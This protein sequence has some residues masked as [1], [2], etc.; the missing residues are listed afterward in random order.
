MCELGISTSE[1]YHDLQING[2]HICLHKYM[3]IYIEENAKR[4]RR[5]RRKL[6]FRTLYRTLK[7]H[8]N[9]WTRYQYYLTAAAVVAVVG[10]MTATESGESIVVSTAEIHIVLI[11]HGHESLFYSFYITLV[12]ILLH[13]SDLAHTTFNSQTIYRRLLPPFSRETKG[14]LFEWSQH[15]KLGHIFSHRK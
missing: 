4:S 2:I 15:I 5:N 6:Q 9:V 14:I 11:V 13:S 10:L 3:F 12:I 7:T 8:K 1:H